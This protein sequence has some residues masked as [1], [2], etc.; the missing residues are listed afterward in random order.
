MGLNRL[1]LSRL[2]CVVFLCIAPAGSLAQSTPPPQQN[3]PARQ[4]QG[5]LRAT[6]RLVVVDVV[7]T[8]GRGSP[9]P[10][11]KVGDFTVLEDG[12]PQKI[13][14]F[15]FQQSGAK[16]TQVSLRL[17]P[18]VVSNIPQHKAT[19]LNVVLLDTLNGDFAG[20]AA[21]Q[22]AL[23]KYLDSAELTQP[24]AIFAMQGKL[25]L[26]HDFTT[27]NKALRAVVAKF[28]PPAQTNN[29][30]S[31][32]S[33]S[34]PFTTKGDFHTG[35]R[36]IEA[37]LNQLH[38][39]AR[40]L[41]GYPGRKNVIWLSEGFPL[42]LAPETATHDS[43]GP[44]SLGEGIT[45]AQTTFD[46]VRDMNTTHDYSALVKKVTDAMMSAQV[47][48][49]AVDS[50]GLGKD[51]HLASQHTMDDLA[52]STGGRAFYNRNDLEVSL[53][54]SLDDGATYYTLTY[55]PD[56]KQWDGKF[57]AISIRTTRPGANLR[58]RLGYYALDPDAAAKDEPKRIAE[59]F[60]R[61]L[62]LDA[63][64][65][66]AVQFQARVVLPSKETQG[67]VVVNFAIDPHTL[68]FERKDDGLMHAAVSCV[69][70][71]Y[72]GKGD[73]IRSEGGVVKGDLK[74]EVYEQVMKSYFPCQRPIELPRGDYT[75]RL[76]VLDRTSHHM[77][78]T[79]ASA[80][81]P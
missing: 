36:N 76:G 58:Y 48:I 15:S 1:P 7:A 16:V 24:L 41:G 39:L 13:S 80:S 55:Y 22:D 33:R 60:S 51:D 12:Q 57:R 31:I 71:A 9:V 67:K 52:Y 32:E 29:A 18:N 50:T 25:T 74:P 26:L 6:T 81:V 73:P 65:I 59:D 44:A 11:L 49:Y 66:T 75:L 46:V 19:S 47:A 4:P 38:T 70:W 79:M 28:K 21:A 61:A 35:E 3:G 43:T 2:F 27:D 40:T 54:T 72:H 10:D 17:P 53:R 56:N 20:H 23:V 34:S 5:V 37:T 69:V 62:T 45:R 30:E 14:S 8:D 64:A 77:G 42:V 63:P 68:V 78:T